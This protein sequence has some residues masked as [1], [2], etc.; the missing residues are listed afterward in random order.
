MKGNS[1]QMKKR[2][3]SLM[4]ACLMLISMFPATALAEGIAATDIT[5]SPETLTLFVDGAT[6]DLTATL[7]PEGAVGTVEWTSSNDEVAT[8]ADGTV[9][10]VAAGKATITATVGEFSDTC[11]V[12]VFAAGTVAAIG[13]TGYATLA[14]ALVAAKSTETIVLM[15]D[16]NEGS[17]N[18]GSKIL[19]LD[20]N[21]HMLTGVAENATKTTVKNSDAENQKKLAATGTYANDVSTFVADEYAVKADDNTTVC[22]AKYFEVDETKY[23]ADEFSNAVAAAGTIKLLQNSNIGEFDFESKELTIDLNGFLLTGSASDAANVTITSSSSNKATLAVVG[24][25]KNE[26]LTEFVADGYDVMPTAKNTVFAT[27]TG[28]VYTVKVVTSLTEQDDRDEETASSRKTRDMYAEDIVDVEVRVYGARFVAADVTLTYDT[29]KF[30][31]VSAPASNWEGDY[32]YMWEDEETPTGKTRFYNAK[33][34]TDGSSYY[35]PNKTDAEGTY[36]VLGKFQFEAK[37]VDQEYIGVPFSVKTE[38][39]V[40]G[41]HMATG[42]HAKTYVAGAWSEGWAS[43]AA[44]AIDDASLYND[45][46]N[47]LMR[48][49]AV[50]VNAKPGMTYDMT[51]QSLLMNDYYA[52][53]T[54]AHEKLTDATWTFALL[55]AEQANGTPKTNEEGNALYIDPKTGEQTTQSS[56]DNT[57]VYEAD[58]ETP[59][60]DE[61]TGKPLYIS[62]T[63]DTTQTIEP[64]TNFTAVFEEGK[65]PVTPTV[66]G[67]DI[68]EK[69]DAGDYVVFYKVHKDG[70]ADVEGS[71]AVSI[72]KAQV[73]LVWGENATENV[74]V[75]QNLSAGTKSGLTSDS[76]YKG[77]A[78][79][80]YG[81][82]R[83][84]GYKNADGECP[85][86]ATYQDPL[87]GVHNAVVTMT[88]KDGA[89]PADGTILKDVGMYEYTAKIMNGD[90]EDTNYE[91]SNPKAKV[92][93]DGSTIVG[94]G[95]ENGTEGPE[96]FYD[97]QNHTG[98]V[99]T[100]AEDATEEVNIAYYV[101]NDFGKTW[102]YGIPEGEE[103]PLTEIPAFKDTGTYMV[104]A[105]LTK[106]QY[107]DLTLDTVTFE[108]K[109]VVFKVESFDWVTGWDI[110][111]VYTNEANVGFTYDGT[112]MYDMSNLA[113]KYAYGDQNVGK[114]VKAGKDIYTY[115]YGLVVYGDADKSLVDPSNDYAKMMKIDDGAAQGS[116]YDVNNTGNIDINDLVAVQGTY[117]VS[118]QYLNAEQMAVV[119]KADVNRD[120]LV[121]TRDCSQIKKNSPAT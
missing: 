118:A 95:L 11:A 94:Y 98:V 3:L 17:Y 72:A 21:G 101:S 66:Y 81:D 47:I 120:K 52:M 109:N 32:D 18:F 65:S 34:T 80:F 56:A 106:E 92:L 77:V 15:A 105:V 16:V 28:S 25:F 75:A 33:A 2:L 99:L 103:G 82:F 97:N 91:I 57:P 22:Y 29:T 87:N 14:A 4:L 68:P 61:E 116:Q 48:K 20:L 50:N 5:V 26:D 112:F 10:A 96:V 110:V 71:I 121:D 55:T 60:L 44:N 58:G 46:A 31:M 67:S 102:T 73:T 79:D 86:Y 6:A 8:V 88:A 62:Y 36:Y 114:G 74:V 54:L 40:E 93:I 63:D 12:T 51:S 7:A 84:E 69:T 42:S 35:V 9:T 64:K 53:D 90:V 37:K 83:A 59:K 115:V 43:S 19:A 107:Y 89:E 111:L 1:N 38:E 27:T 49:M 13:S 119:L 108:V 85:I 113:D 104:K 78:T 45:Y 117:N 70:Y 41:K 39:A 23:G 100:K 24:A 30:Q 76:P